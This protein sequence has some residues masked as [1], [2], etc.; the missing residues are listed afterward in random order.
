MLVIGLGFFC[1]PDVIAIGFSDHDRIGHFHDTFFN[2]LQFITGTGQHQQQE[3][4]NQISH[5][6]F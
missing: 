3:K 5:T 2:S 6:G 1:T 4:V